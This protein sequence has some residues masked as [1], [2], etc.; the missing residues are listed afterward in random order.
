MK[1]NMFSF[2]SLKSFFALALSILL[3][4]CGN[5]FLS[6]GAVSSGSAKKSSS[7]GTTGTVDGTLAG[8]EQGSKTSDQSAYILLNLNSLSGVARTIFPDQSNAQDVSNFSNFTLT[9]I[10][11]EDLNSSDRVLLEAESVD[12]IKN[13]VVPIEPGTWT[14]TLRAELDGASFVGYG[15]KAESAS[16]S[17]TSGSGTSGST[18]GSG[19]S[20][21][22]G[23]G[24][25]SDFSQPEPIEIK[26][27]SITPI[28]FELAAAEDFGGLEIK[29]IFPLDENVNCVRAILTSAEDDQPINENVYK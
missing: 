24:S 2:F 22:T 19:T 18:S 6:S 17:G 7:Q 9:G 14:F 4:S 23:S 16:G 12:D 11:S 13:Q 25:S 29:V 20:G 8:G 10:R 1:K 3:V 5:G 27:S 28:S 21:D 26:S 15:V